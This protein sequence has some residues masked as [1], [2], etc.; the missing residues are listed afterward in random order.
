LANFPSHMVYW[1]A[2]PVTRCTASL[3]RSKVVLVSFPAH[4]LY[5][6]EFPLIRCTRSLP[7]SHARHTRFPAHTLYSLDFPLIRCT[8]SLPYSHAKQSRF[9]AHTLFWLEFPLI[10]CTRS[11]PYSHARQTRFP[12]QTLC[13]H[14]G[15]PPNVPLLL[16][17]TISN[18]GSIVRGQNV[19]VRQWKFAKGSARNF[20]LEQVPPTKHHAACPLADYNLALNES[21]T[22]SHCCES[23]QTKLSPVL[24]ALAAGDDKSRC[25]ADNVCILNATCSADTALLFRRWKWWEIV[26]TNYEIMAVL[27]SCLAMAGTA[28]DAL[29]YS[30][31]YS[32]ILEAYRRSASNL[33][34]NLRPLLNSDVYC[35]V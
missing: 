34:K 31:E 29:L 19:E 33:L 28:A 7:Y 22:A 17:I 18:M 12:A 8:R 20:L 23:S 1:L 35:K 2:F 11:L 16:H 4:T 3:S 26:N 24:P 10:R 30:M 21:A 14:T 15:H 27:F 13:R 6:L 9:P 32:C 5:W 25:K